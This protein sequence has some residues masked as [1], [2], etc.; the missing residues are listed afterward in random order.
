MS[1]EQTAA[2]IVARALAFA[3][4]VVLVSDQAVDAP[5]PLERVADLDD[6]EAELRRRVR[7]G[8]CVVLT[9]RVTVD[10]VVRDRVLRR[11][12]AWGATGFWCGDAD[13]PT[14]GLAL[15]VASHD[16]V[17]TLARIFV[18]AEALVGDQAAL[19]PGLADVSGEVC[20]TC[21]DEGRLGEVVAPPEQL[22]APAS[23]RTAAG[24]EDVDVSIVGDV[25]E[26]DLVLIHAG[27]AI[28]R[29]PEEET[30]ARR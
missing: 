25:H 5:F 14:D 16:P 30:E 19:T 21:S 1:D 23:V 28:A 4:R 3:G 15:C 13:R 11:L 20:I 24:I 6:C 27:G 9:D 29:I 2:T 17:G 22:F 12:P 7:T 10:A 18:H 8:D 26:G